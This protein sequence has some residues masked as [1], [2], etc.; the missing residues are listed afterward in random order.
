MSSY[1]PSAGCDCQIYLLRWLYRALNKQV[2][3][4]AAL[5]TMEG[6]I[7]RTKGKREMERGKGNKWFKEIS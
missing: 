6:G 5:E 7:Q 2:F 3:G 4:S 1:V